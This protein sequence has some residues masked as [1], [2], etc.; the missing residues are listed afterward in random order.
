MIKTTKGDADWRTAPKTKYFEPA[1]KN[2]VKVYLIENKYNY[3]VLISSTFIYTLKL[4]ALC[5][6]FKPIHM[7]CIILNCV[8]NLY[9]RF[10]FC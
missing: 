8:K 5:R 7:N 6:S 10:Y 3:G 2:N 4:M 1:A 9:V